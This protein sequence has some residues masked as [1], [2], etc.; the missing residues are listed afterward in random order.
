LAITD[1][2]KPTGVTMGIKRV[3]DR[4]TVASLKMKGTIYGTSRARP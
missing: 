3:D 4:H 1:L 2:G